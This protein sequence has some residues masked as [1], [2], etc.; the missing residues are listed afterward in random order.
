MKGKS[1]SLEEHILIIDDRPES[2]NLLRKIL[3]ESGYKLHLARECEI[4]L[5]F[6]QSKPP[7]LILL[8]IMMPQMNGY[9]VCDLLKASERTKEIPVIFISALNE[10]SDK[11]EAFSKGGVD[12]ITKP[13]Q[14]EEV[15]ARVESQLRSSRLS[16]QLRQKN[17]VLQTIFNHIPVMISLHDSNGQVDLVNPELERILGWKSKELE[18][19]DLLA[20]CYPNPDVRASFV[21]HMNAATGKWQ[22][23]KTRIHSGKYVDTSWVN[24]QLSNGTNIAIGQDISERLANMRRESQLA[25]QK[26]HYRI[27]REI[28]DELAQL[29]SGVVMNIDTVKA[30]LPTKESK[31]TTHIDKAYR[32]AK[33]ALEETRNLISMLRHPKKLEQ[34]SLSDDLK[35]LVKEL[36]SE[37]S[38]Q[39][40]CNNIEEKLYPLY[41]EVKTNILRIAQEAMNNIIKHANASAVEVELTFTN[42]IIKLRIWDD[43][44]GFDPILLNPKGFGLV[45]MHERIQEI[46]GELTIESQPG[47]GTEILAS[48][49]FD[50]SN[51]P[52]NTNEMEDVP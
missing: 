47:Q 26:E 17:E 21:E 12:Y 44:R 38:I 7:D 23:F 4:A 14:N 43:G 52:N 2:L 48:L 6:A 20:E 15:L 16:K 29:L 37:T 18:A 50:T 24:I 25:K 41:P 35:S 8:D 5:Q 13:F 3:S 31:I 30:V 46:G 51:F 27:A 1:N 40:S 32:L 19:I 45:G 36:F 42:Q 10:V 22:D 39:P 11:I 49:P 33:K 28:H 34:T 9:E